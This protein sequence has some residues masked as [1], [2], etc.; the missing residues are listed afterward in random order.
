MMIGLP[1]STLETELATAD[2]IINC[3]ASAAR[4]YPTVVFR[5]TELCRK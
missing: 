2:F 1:Y 3:G 4:I 5:D